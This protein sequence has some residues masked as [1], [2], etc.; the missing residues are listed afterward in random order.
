MTTLHIRPIDV[1]TDDNLPLYQRN[2]FST[3]VPQKDQ[4]ILV[5][6]I[7]CSVAWESFGNNSLEPVIFVRNRQND[8]ARNIR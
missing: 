2:I 4:H 8:K 5:D 7:V 6:F 3:G 1:E